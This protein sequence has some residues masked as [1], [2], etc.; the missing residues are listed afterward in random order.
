M[1]LSD[2]I[3][4]GILIFCTVFGAFGAFKWLLHL[5]AGVVFGLVILVC[6]GLLADNPQF[7]ELSRGIFKQGVVI[8]YIRNQITAVQHF[9]SYTDA[10]SFDEI[11]IS[12]GG[13]KDE[14]IAP[15]N[16]YERF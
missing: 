15:E 11:A 13:Q 4:I 2:K 1:A 6:V 7:D 8:P 10:L 9:I 14:A 3:A 5:F 12:A 16:A